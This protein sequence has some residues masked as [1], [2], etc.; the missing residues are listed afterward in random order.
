VSDVGQSLLK[1]A[2]QWLLSAAASS[3]LKLKVLE[4]KALSMALCCQ[5]LQLAALEPQAM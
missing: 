2:C 3:K 5:L 1:G 4:L